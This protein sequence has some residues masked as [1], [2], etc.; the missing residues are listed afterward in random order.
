MFSRATTINDNPHR[1][2]NVSRH[3]RTHARAHTKE[4]ARGGWGWRGGESV[5][6]CTRLLLHVTRELRDTLERAEE[7]KPSA[8]RRQFYSLSNTDA[9]YRNPNPNPSPSPKP[10]P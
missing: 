10:S 5:Y 4:R 2:F 8:L 7:N 6:G 9:K 1:L 3:T